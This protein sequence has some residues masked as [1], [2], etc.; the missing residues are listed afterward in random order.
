MKQNMIRSYCHRCYDLDET[1]WDTIYFLVTYLIPE[2]FI[3]S[4]VG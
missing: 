1:I 3:E 2:H 4:I